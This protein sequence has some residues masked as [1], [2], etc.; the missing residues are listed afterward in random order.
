ME[1]S[2]TMLTA[3]AGRAL[4]AGTPLLLGT[5]G[6]ILTER[7]GIMNLGVEGIMAAGAVT[8]FSVALTT[9][10]P[11]LGVLAAIGCGVLLGLLHAVVTVTLWANQIVA[12]LALTMF[13]LGLSSLIG[14]PFVGRP[15]P[16]AIGEWRIPILADVPVIG[17]CLFARDPI[18]YLGL[19]L[20]GLLW[21]LLFRTRWG[22]AIRSCGEA[23]LASTT[24]G[25]DVQWVRYLCVMAG[26]G[27]SGLAGAYLSLV[28]NPSWVEGM[29]AGR[30]WI[31]IALTIFAFW[32]PLRAVIGAYAFGGIYVVQY[33]LQSWNISPNLLMTLPYVLTLAALMVTSSRANRHLAAPAALGQPF[34]PGEKN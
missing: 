32:N 25:V 28:Y 10:S 27:F 6:E 5:L 34:F 23:P 20:S 16:Q 14:K 19:A 4:V 30:G 3:L 29:S 15:L 18:F 17:E 24:C 12:G 2:L 7:S 8:G 1:L 13:G 31:V 9:G 21:F 33:S 26:G 22:I 11:W